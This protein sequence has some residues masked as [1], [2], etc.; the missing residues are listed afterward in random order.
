MGTGVVLDMVLDLAI[1]R[2]ACRQLGELTC[3]K[4]LKLE[5]AF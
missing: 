4:F 1:W 3:E 2:A 5:I